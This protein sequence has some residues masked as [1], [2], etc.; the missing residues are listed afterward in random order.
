MG[1]ALAWE[2]MDRVQLRT[3]SLFRG[4]NHGFSYKSRLSTFYRSVSAE[5]ARRSKQR[6][7]PTAGRRDTRPKVH[8]VVVQN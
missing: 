5:A 1:G 7:G 6:L 3:G 2:V 4:Q 8:S